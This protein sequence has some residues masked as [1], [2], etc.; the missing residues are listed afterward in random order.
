MTQLRRWSRSTNGGITMRLGLK[1]CAEERTAAELLADA[2]RAEEVGFDFAA[3]SDHFH[4][5]VDAQGESP[6]VWSVLGG[7]AAVTD[8]LE[9]GTAVTCP[10]VRMHPAIVAQAA[11]TAG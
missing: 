2:A 8:Q 5:W 6:F 7:I 1:L 4:P 10:T 9:V 11:A 3:I